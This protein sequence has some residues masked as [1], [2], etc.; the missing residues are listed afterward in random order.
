LCQGFAIN[1]A[2]IED[3]VEAAAAATPEPWSLALLGSGL[4]LL[5]FLRRKLA[6]RQ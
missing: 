3:G 2:R 1:Q 5:G 6:A 4:G